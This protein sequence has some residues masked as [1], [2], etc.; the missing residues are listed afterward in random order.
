M[1]DQRNWTDDSYKTYCT[2]LAL[3]FPA[4]LHK[5]DTVNQTISLEIENT[6]GKLSSKSTENS[7]QF[8]YTGEKVSMPNIGIGASSEYE[9]LSASSVDI[10]KQIP[11]HHYRID[12]NFADKIWEKKLEQGMISANKLGIKLLIA[13]FYS[14][15][16]VEET[17]ALVRALGEFK[18]KVSTIY[19]FDQQGK[20]TS[21]P[22][23]E[24]VMQPL[25]ANFPNALI[26][27]GTNVYFTELNRERVSTSQIDLLTYS[28]NPQVHAFD[29][30]SLTETLQAQQYTVESALQFSKG[31]PVHVSPITLQPRFNPNATGEPPAPKAGELPSQTDYRQ[32]SLYAASWLVGSIQYL[33]AAKCKQVTY[34]ETAGTRGILQGENPPALPNKFKSF[35]GAIFPVYHVLKF[36]LGNIPKEVSLFKS[37]SRLKS[38]IL[39]AI[40]EKGEKRAI[41]TNFSQEQLQIDIQANEC[42]TG[43]VKFLISEPENMGAIMQASDYLEKSNF[44]IYHP[45]KGN[46]RFK[47]PA[48]GLIFIM[49]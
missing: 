9:I 40:N 8:H 39:L 6:I 1:E 23:I 7:V 18:S 45:V 32:M 12:I 20:T 47:L 37:S 36:L 35:A 43:E 4:K 25:R 16:A 21:D 22:L 11:F 33:A 38:E 31:L 27:A 5:G 3:P 19:I 2:P 24:K 30:D 17:A 15:K 44:E 13:L 29:N 48:F 10:I 42:L 28:V 26:G 14:Q 34:F 49:S 46:Y 41:I